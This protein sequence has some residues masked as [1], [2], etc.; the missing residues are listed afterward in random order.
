MSRLESIK[1]RLAYFPSELRDGGFSD[2]SLEFGA[3]LDIDYLLQRLERYETSLKVISE[4][5]A[6]NALIHVQTLKQVAEE[7]LKEGNHE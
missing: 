7:A 5:K 2:N 4:F 1:E 3:K 6:G